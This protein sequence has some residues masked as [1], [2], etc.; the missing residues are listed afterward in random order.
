MPALLRL[1]ARWRS[2]ELF[3]LAVVA[4]GVGIGYATWLTGL[5]FAFGAFVAGMVLSESEF[6]HQALSDVIPLRD[7]FGLLFFASVGMLVDPR[8]LIENPL[9]VATAVGVVVAGKALILAVI[10]RLFGYAN[11]AP[12]IVGLGLAQIG[13]FSFLLT[14]E[15]LRLGV[16][17]HDAYS[18]ALTTTVA[19]MVLTPAIAGAAPA[20]Y[21]LLRR[22][23]PQERPIETHAIPE[24]GLH[25]HVV[26]VGYGRTGRAVV[27]VMRR[28]DLG[29]VTIE[30]DHARFGDC[31][32]GVGPAVWGDATQEPVLHAAAIERAQMLVITIPDLAGIKMIVEHAVALNPT[33]D[34]IARAVSPESLDELNALPVREVVQP[35]LEAGLEMVRQVLARCRFGPADIL[36]FSD[37]V[38]RELYGG[39]RSAR[40]D[41]DGLVV[42]D[43]LRRAARGIA[44]EWIPVAAG[45][46]VAGTTIAATGLRSRTGASIVALRAAGGVQPNPGPET[47]VEPGAVLGVLGTPEQLQAA[48]ALVEGPTVTAPS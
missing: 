3:L 16:L 19:T 10:T 29:F 48:R 14:R 34:I 17:D 12:L 9:A 21:R 43:D 27:E 42:L 2:R 6:S 47:R 41:G 31:A 38:H 40:R 20:L 25:D 32:R 24:P 18:L 33:I 4:L 45:S 28:T 23:V 1:I 36:R 37:A 26:V 30:S 35:E 8:Y 7:V 15:G 39:F 46:P 44:I 11:M 5:S 13:E 22:V